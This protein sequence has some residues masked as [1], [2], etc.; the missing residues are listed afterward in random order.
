MFA[1]ILPSPLLRWD[2]MHIV[3]NLEMLVR[4]LRVYASSMENVQE[5]S[6]EGEGDAIRILARVSYKGIATRVRIDVAEIRLK[7][8]H[9]GFRLRQPR[10]LG[11]MPLPR[12]MVEQGLKFAGLDG[13]TVVAGEGI[14]IVDLRRWIPEQV[15]FSIRTVQ[16]SERCIH[17]WLGSGLIDDIPPGKVKSLPAGH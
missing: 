11:G 5:L 12:S 3:L 8:R 9:L 2:G 17:I 14:V 4:Y 7:H 10:A 1:K 6:L 15:S 13:L 16:A